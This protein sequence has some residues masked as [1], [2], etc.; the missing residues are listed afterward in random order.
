MRIFPLVVI[1]IYP[2]I[3]FKSCSGVVIGFILNFSTKISKTF[4]DTNAGNVGPNRMFSIPK[5]SNLYN[6]QTAFCSYHDKTIDNGSSLTE[7]LNA[8]AN[9]D[10]TFIA[11]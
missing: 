4:G 11:L 2:N 10:A 6:T 1:S 8:F 9:S 3:S 5:Y 7:Q